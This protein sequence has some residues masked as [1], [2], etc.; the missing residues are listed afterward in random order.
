MLDEGFC[1]L[2][3]N[4][5]S[6]PSVS[7]LGEGRSL[8]KIL[9]PWPH[10]LILPAREYD[11]EHLVIIRYFRRSSDGTIMRQFGPSLRPIIPD[12]EI[13]NVE[14]AVAGLFRGQYTSEQAVKNALIALFF[15]IFVIPLTVTCQ[16]QNLGNEPGE[17]TFT[18]TR[19]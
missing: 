15:P 6:L 5:T 19:H 9:L 10:R 7:I 4:P 12:C 8:K 17:T 3:T 14:S 1:Y 11:D 18:V 13:E 2:R 16:W